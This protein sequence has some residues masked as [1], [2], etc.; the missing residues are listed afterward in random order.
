MRK[1]NIMIFI[2]SNMNHVIYTNMG[3]N[4][5]KI[6][7]EKRPTNHRVISYMFVMIGR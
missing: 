3:I 6:K 5:K 7:K 2:I 1:N 4:K